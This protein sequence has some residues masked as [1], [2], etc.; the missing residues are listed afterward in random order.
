VTA[1]WRKARN[2]IIHNVLHADDTPHRLALGVA[3]G[4]FVAFTPTIGLQTILAVGLAA[5]L[6]ANKL[7]CIPLVWVTNPVTG[8]PIY[9]LCYRLGAGLIGSHPHPPQ[10]HI[11]PVMGPAE[12]VLSQGLG[13]LVA[14]DFWRDILAGLTRVGAQLWVGCLLVGFVL[15]VI[16][17]FPCRWF[18]EH[19]RRQRLALFRA[20]ALRRTE[21]RFRKPRVH[22]QEPL[23]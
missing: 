17:Y 4:M 19:Y 6:R 21:R 9:A 5:L 16:S 14:W 15:A 2:F 3:I 20:R 10:E 22:A 8:V 18:I 11:G 7:I 23:A 12:Q 13:R 1:T